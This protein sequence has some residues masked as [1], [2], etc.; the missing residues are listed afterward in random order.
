M[1]TNSL[2]L[3]IGIRSFLVYHAIILDLHTFTLILGL[4]A[5]SSKLM[6]DKKNFGYS[7]P[8]GINLTNSRF[9]PT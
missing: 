1:E 3:T 9:N 7:F 4:D 5:R 8:F 6:L 2:F